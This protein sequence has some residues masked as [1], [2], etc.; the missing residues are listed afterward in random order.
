MI[1]VELDFNFENF[2]YIKGSL[3]NEWNYEE[4]GPDAWPH[5]FDT[6]KGIEQSP[7]N[8]QKSNLTY[9][10]NLKEIN[11]NNYN[12]IISMNLFHNG[13]TSKLR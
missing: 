11:F 5:L 6:C 8:I 4:N 10:P 13:H 2:I 9:N 7:I 1:P 3:T 12:Q